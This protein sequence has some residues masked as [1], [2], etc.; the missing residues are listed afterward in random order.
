MLYAL[1]FDIDRSVGDDTRVN[2][3]FRDG[4]PTIILCTRPYNSISL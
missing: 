3:T 1:D 4:Q 2:R